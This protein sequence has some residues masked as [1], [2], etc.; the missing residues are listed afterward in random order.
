M[1]HVIWLVLFVVLATVFQPNAVVAHGGGKIQVTAEPVEPYLVSVW[2]NPPV[3]K[4]GD[5][6]H[7]TVGVA[8]AGDRS[9]VLDAEVLVEVFVAEESPNSGKTAVITTTATTDRS[10]NKLF[11]E[12]DFI[13]PEAELYTI[14]VTVS[15]SDGGGE[16]GFD[17]PVVAANNRWFGLIGVIVLGAVG[18]LIMLSQ[19]QEREETAVSSTKQPRR[20][21]G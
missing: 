1:R 20:R 11:Y 6:I 8:E 9:F 18:V 13:L 10:T 5:L 17:M 19:R 2:T 7:V 21:Q 14:V 16:V 3:A 15:N 12:T 4:A